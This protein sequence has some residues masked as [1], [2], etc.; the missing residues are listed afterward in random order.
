MRTFH[1]A[2]TVLLASACMAT[3]A[4][5]CS[6]NLYRVGK[7]KRYRE[8]TAPIPGNILLVGDK[9]QNRVM[10]EWLTHAGHKVQVV[11][12]AA[13]LGTFL[14]TDQYDMVLASYGVQSTVAAQTAAN[15]S[16]AKYLPIADEK[17]DEA[18]LKI[19]SGGEFVSAKAQPKELLKAIHRILKSESNIKAGT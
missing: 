16:H 2:M 9:P 5:A 18:T 17:A 14:Q 11:E 12:D 8:Y 1:L 7:G 4:A 19:A 6:E 10:A 3:T 15:K 13:R